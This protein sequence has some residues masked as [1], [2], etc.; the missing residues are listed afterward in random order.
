ME[1][2]IAIALKLML[3]GMTT[4]SVI[5]I[6]I[7]FSAKLLI[8]IINH[9]T[10]DPTNISDKDSEEHIAAISGVVDIITGGRGIIQ[11]IKKIDNG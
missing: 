11:K 9:Y 3:I 8:R 6:L 10:P 5:L 4:V 2:N 1:E 7:I